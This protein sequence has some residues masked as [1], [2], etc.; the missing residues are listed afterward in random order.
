MNRLKVLFEKIKLYKK[1]AISAIFSLLALG[2]I[3]LA[4]YGSVLASSNGPRTN[5]ETSKINN[6]SGLFRSQG[7]ALYDPKGNVFHVRGVNAGNLLLQEGW[8]SPFSIEAT[9]GK[10]G[11]YVYPEFTEEDFRDGLKK[12]P[13]CG[14]E[15]LVI[16][17][18]YYY[19]Q[20]WT[21]EDFSRVKALGLNTIRL[22][23]YWKNILNDDFT[24]KEEGKAFAFIDSFIEGAKEQKL[25]IILDLH[26]APGSQNGLEHSGN[27]SEGAALWDNERFIEATE[28]VWALVAEHYLQM[29]PD[30]ASTILCYDLLNEPGVKDPRNGSITTTKKCYP[31][32]D[33]LYKAIRN[34]GDQHVI[35]MEFAWFFRESCNPK[36]YGWENVLY[37]LHFYNFGEKEY[38]EYWMDIKKSS[39]GNRYEIPYLAGEFSFFD[40]ERDWMENLTALEKQLG[41]GWTVWNYKATVEREADTSWGLYVNKMRL[42]KGERKLDISSCTFEEFKKACDASRTDENSSGI[43]LKAIRHF[44]QSNPINLSK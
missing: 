22:P 11:R 14:P 1:L 13:N 8:L 15:N 18:E 20:W 2:S 5:L 25:Y 3:G 41:F 19:E 26:G 10:N 38:D 21:K 39:I 37:Q 44:I 31:V 17:Q 9:K 6:P 43:T 29:R 40:K 36:D 27:M 12:N 23:F 28:R 16:W 42:K 35:S 30:L 34:T 4:T 7:K 33:R 24:P 32:F